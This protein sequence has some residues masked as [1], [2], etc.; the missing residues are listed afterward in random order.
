MESDGISVSRIDDTGDDF[1]Q[2]V[3][4]NKDID[5]LISPTA[6]PRRLGAG[7]NRGFG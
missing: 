2:I 6:V 3:I 4:M 1:Y 5:C 7:E